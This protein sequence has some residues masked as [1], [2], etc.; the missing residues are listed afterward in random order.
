MQEVNNW[1]TFVALYNHG[2]LIK[3]SNLNTS[4]TSI[5]DW[6]KTDIFVT[7]MYAIFYMD[8]VLV[9]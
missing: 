6:L 8:G 9:Y 2:C 3:P 1:M 4:S 7:Q 5:F